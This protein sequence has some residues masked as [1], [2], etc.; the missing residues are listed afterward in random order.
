M[1]LNSP[2]RVYFIFFLSK[3]AQNAGGIRFRYALHWAKETFSFSNN[4]I[5]NLL[6][7][8]FNSLH[9]HILKKLIFKK[10]SRFF[11]YYDH[12]D[13]FIL[14]SQLSIQSLLITRLFQII[15]QIQFKTFKILLLKAKKGRGDL[16]ETVKMSISCILDRI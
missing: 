3:N 5:F 13:I 6:Y 9:W 12:S 2:D 7:F 10:I 16:D 4:H 1:A 14:S 15:N 11:W 8:F